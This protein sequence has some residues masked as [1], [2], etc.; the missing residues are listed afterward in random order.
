M[1]PLR[2]VLFDCDGTLVDSAGHIVNAME[3]AFAAHGL[4][5][6]SA[7]KVKSIIGLSLP[8]AVARLAAGAAA[9]HDD[10]VT[11]YKDFY[12]DA[13]AAGAA[14]EPLF[15]GTLDAIEAIA[16][17]AVLGVVTGKSRRGLDRILAGHGL[18]RHFATTVTADDAPSKPAPD[19]VHLALA[20]TGADAIHTVVVGDSAFDME[21]ARA[22]GAK[23]I[24]VSWG[25]HDV[26]R[27]KQAGAQ[28]FATRM[29]DLPQLVNECL[30]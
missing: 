27:L 15:P 3:K 20:E 23:A 11:A 16:Q 4:E 26:A 13:A 29:A 18:Q 24:G 25:Y 5:P 12:A 28:A 21:M 2:L 10:I 6:P 7:G 22:A 9:A 8:V 17:V 1:S 19:M 14:K 30:P